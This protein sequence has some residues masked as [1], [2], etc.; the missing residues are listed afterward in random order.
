MPFLASI[1]LEI[2][3]PLSSRR[4]CYLIAV[5][6]EREKIPNPYIDK[7]KDYVSYSN[8]STQIISAF[9]LTAVSALSLPFLRMKLTVGI[10]L[11][12]ILVGGMLIFLY[13][14]ELLDPYKWATKRVKNYSW[15]SLVGI[16][17]NIILVV[18]VIV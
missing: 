2:I 7:I 10:P 14:L 17:L 16:V 5:Y 13:Y 4:I 1:F 8:D 12:I 9:F 6:A 18:L 15:A 3:S 11:V